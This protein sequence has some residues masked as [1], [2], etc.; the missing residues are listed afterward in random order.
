MSNISPT[1]S[2]RWTL[3]YGQ[4]VIAILAMFTTGA[5]GR[6]FLEAGSSPRVGRLR[7]RTAM[8]PGG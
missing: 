3:Q 4:C 1:K 6:D 8:D 2:P 7:P 5:L